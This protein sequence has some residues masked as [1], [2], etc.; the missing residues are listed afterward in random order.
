MDSR[1]ETGVAPPQKRKSPLRQF[2][3]GDLVEVRGA[4]EILNTLDEE[5]TL[6]G[7]PFMP[8]MI[9]FIGRR[10]TVAWHIEKTCLDYPAQSFRRF[11]HNDVVFL[12]G[13]RCPGDAHGDCQRGCK[14]FWKEAWLQK[15]QDQ[16]VYP[17]PASA[18]DVEAL[19]NRIKTVAEEDAYIC[20]SSRL[21]LAT[22]YIAPID[23]LKTAYTEINVGNRGALEMMFLLARTAFWKIRGKLLGTHP[24]GKLKKTPTET[25][26]LEP[27]EWV[28][29][30]SY[31]EIYP[32]LDHKGRNRGMRFDLDQR[33]FCGKRFRVQRR[34]DRMIRE[35]SGQ[36]LTPSNT[37]ILEG[38]N[39]QC[40]FATGGCPRA[41][42]FYWREIW[43]KRIPG[44][45]NHAA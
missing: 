40:I 21:E 38:V 29:V 37:V 36:M 26:D 30:K 22:E 17:E 2:R 11:R 8:E 15:V 12:E 39:C 35:D 24:K 10:F 33:F 3:R 1:A 42:A 5:G 32:T 6:D 13:L 27:G 41:E 18:K 25:L 45:D 7:L 43:L 23:R 4:L 31:E 14:I 28:E 44:P 19:R 20:Q 34:L 9:P 16:A